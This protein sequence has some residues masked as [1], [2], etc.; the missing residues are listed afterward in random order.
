MIKNLFIARLFA[1]LTLVALTACNNS[2]PPSTESKADQH[3]S[4]FERGP[5]NGRL[6]RDGELAI[7]IAIFESGT[8][9]EFRVYATEKSKAL[10][11][12]E[13]KLDV[14]LKRFAGVTDHH[15]FTAKNDYLVSAAEVYEPHSFDVE[16]N[17]TYQNKKHHWEYATYEGRTTISNVMA[18]ASGIET[19]AVASGTIKQT[20]SLYGTVQPDAARVRAI[21]ARFPGVIRNVSADIGTQVS[22]G[23]VLAQ[24]ESNE[25]LQT[26][27]V[28]SPITGIVIRRRANQGETAGAEPL[29]DVAD[30]SQLWAVLN[31][32]PRDRAKIKAGQSALINSADGFA[33]TPGKI[34]AIVNGV[35][36]DDGVHAQPTLNARVL[37]DNRDGQWIAGQFINADVVVAES[38]APFVVPLTALQTY[39]DGDAVFLNEGETYQAQPILLGKRDNEN[40]EILSG[41]TAGTQIVVSNSYLIKAD[42][43]KSGASHDH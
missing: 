37:L 3:A 25:S 22:A 36:I 2:T 41:L 19:R 6:L 18:Q 9:P 38:S 16:V 32:F 34:A 20:I 14:E 13:I 26:Y 29:F 17:A 5:H 27:A 10:N 33:K 8:A 39:R 24:I 35:A 7:E 11:P 1:A 30:Y 15:S 43:E 21:T 40:V 4:D 31:I 28:T 23:Q 42:I 12:N